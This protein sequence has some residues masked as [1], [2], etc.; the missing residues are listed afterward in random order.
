MEHEKSFVFIPCPVHRPPRTIKDLLD[1]P[2]RGRKLQPLSH[3][4]PTVD[5]YPI[6]C[7]LLPL[8]SMYFVNLRTGP[9]HQISDISLTHSPTHLEFSRCAPNLIVSR[10]SVVQTTQGVSGAY[11]AL[12]RVQYRLDTGQG[13]PG[14]GCSATTHALRSVSQYNLSAYPPL[15]TLLKECFG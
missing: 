2:P 7:H 11:Q 12:T 6:F 14:S 1:H 13:Q 5:N 4:A 15:D 3:S 10:S 8:F 9:F